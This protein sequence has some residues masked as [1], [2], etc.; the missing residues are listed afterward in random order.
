MV[1]YNGKQGFERIS[2]FEFSEK[3]QTKL[4]PQPK[5]SPISQIISGPA[6]KRHHIFSILLQHYP[7]HQPHIV[8]PEMKCQCWGKGASG[9]GGASNTTMG[10]PPCSSQPT[11]RGKRINTFALLTIWRVII[12]ID[13]RKD[14]VAFLTGLWGVMYNYFGGWGLES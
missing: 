2:W 6:Q 10:S 1:L 3:Q 8:F 13:R 14:S 5:F 12:F 4:V 9:H 7:D 11:M